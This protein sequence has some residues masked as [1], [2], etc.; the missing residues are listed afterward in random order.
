MESTV[1]T[2]ISTAILPTDAP[3]PDHISTPS[4]KNMEDLMMQKGT[5]ESLKLLVYSH[6]RIDSR[7][8]MVTYFQTCW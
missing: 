8:I 3:A 4:T 5:R 2:F 6:G 7:I 1:F